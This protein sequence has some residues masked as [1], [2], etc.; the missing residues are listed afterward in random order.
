MIH[1]IIVVLALV[2]VACFGC[3]LYAWLYAKNQGYTLK[4]LWNIYNDIED[5]KE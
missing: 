1:L 5:K 4:Q 3:F 2:I